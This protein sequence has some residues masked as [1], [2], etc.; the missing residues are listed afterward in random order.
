[1]VKYNFFVVTFDST[2]IHIRRLKMTVGTSLCEI[3]SY[4]LQKMPR[5]APKA[6]IYIV[7]F[8]MNQTIFSQILCV[9]FVFGLEF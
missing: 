2:N 5:K 1:M 7:R 3:F 9:R 6:A 8:F 4:I